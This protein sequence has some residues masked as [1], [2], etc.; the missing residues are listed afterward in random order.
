M[1]NNNL[2]YFQIRPNANFEENLSKGKI[3]LND[4]LVKTNIKPQENTFFTRP[5]TGNGNRE[6]FR[7]RPNVDPEE[8]ISNEKFEF[9]DE[10]LKTNVKP[11]GNTFF[12]KPFTENEEEIGIPNNFPK[13]NTIPHGNSFFEKPSTENSIQE[14]LSIRPE[15][16]GKHENFNEIP[17]TNLIP[18]E[19]NFFT[20]PIAGSGETFF[21]IPKSKVKSEGITVESNSIQILKDEK[22]E[23]SQTTTKVISI[24]NFN[25]R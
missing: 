12:T 7:I 6:K 3:E 4:E 16:V 20:K 17:K 2:P 23:F 15:T 5:I 14:N 24:F 13:K 25:L 19:N 11:H 21:N 9:N 22:H 8:N 18:D 10:F 1:W